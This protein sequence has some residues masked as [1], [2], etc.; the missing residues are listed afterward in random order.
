MAVTLHKTLVLRLSSIGD[1]ILA[2]PFLRALKTAFPAASIDVAVKKE[3]ASLLEHNPHVDRCIEVDTS[4]GNEALHTLRSALREHRYD[5]VF[6]LHNNFRTRLLRRGVAPTVR[7]VRKRSIRRLLLVRWKINLLRDTPGISKRYQETCEGM[8][9]TVDAGPPEV[10]VPVD[11]ENAVA[12]R[13]REAGVDDAARVLA[14]APG[15][16]HFTK[17]WP[18]EHW[19][20]LVAR[21]MLDEG[22]KVLLLGGK[23]DRDAAETISRI[24]PARVVN[25]CGELS[26]L[27]TAAALSRCAAACTNDSG[28]MHLATARGV[29]VVALFGSTVREFGFFPLGERN[30]VLE[31][32]GLSCRP[33]TH[34]GRD[35]CPALHFRCLR[36]IAPATVASALRRAA[37]ARA[38]G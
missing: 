15:A 19:A 14:L 13:L 32:E 31:V 24:A 4:A 9:I 12:A 5:A 23:E 26:L 18:A 27:E 29:P 3:F 30:T 21:L 33:C 36:D 7:V 38:R 10:F 34:I 17:R 22:T 25:L 16:R 35:R 2:T 28:L 37:E 6:D 8:G 11:V 20:A 1:V